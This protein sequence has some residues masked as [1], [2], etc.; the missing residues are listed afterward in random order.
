M[1]AFE[2]CDLMIV[3]VV[4]VVLCVPLPLDHFFFCFFPPVAA[5]AWCNLSAPMRLCE[6]IERAVATYH[7]V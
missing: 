1:I 5:G 2:E 3:V 6:S 4:V 7:F